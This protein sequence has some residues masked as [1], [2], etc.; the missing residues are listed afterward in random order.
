MTPLAG[1]D[2]AELTAWLTRVT[3]TIDRSLREG[4]RAEALAQLRD[5]L[6]GATAPVAILGQLALLDDCLRVAHLAIE[7]DGRVDPDELARVVE[8]VQV[9][10]PKYFSVLPRYESFGDGAPTPDEAERFLVVH[11]GDE[12]AFGYAS[13]ASWRGLALVRLVERHTRNAAPLRELERMLARIMDEVFAG[14]A[15]AIEQDARRRL[16]ALFEPPPEPGADPRDTAFCRADGPEVFSSVAH[17]SQIHD[18]DPFD[19]ESIHADARDVFHRQVVRAT[20][21]EQHHYG[22]G[23]TLL[24]LGDSGSGKTHLLRA[25]RHQVHAQRLGYVG[26][27]QMTSEVADYARYVLRNL[28][29]SL[30]RPYDAPAFA[31]SGLLYLSDGLAEGRGNLAPADVERLR[32]AEL[33]SD[34]LDRLLG[35]LVDQILRGD[36]LGQLEPDLV[37]ALLLLQRRDP[38]LQRRVIRFL[39]CEPLSA[40]ERRLLGGL[41]ARDQPDDPMRTLR[42]L[43]TIAYELQMATL[44]L[45]VDQIEDIVPDGKTVARLQQAIDVLRGI[46]D[47]VP[48][49]VVVMACLD[50]VYTALRGKLSQSVIDR[51]ERDPAPVRLASQR[52][53]EDIEAML[54]RRLDHLYSTFDVAIQDDDPCYPFTPD[55]LEAVTKLRARDAIAKFREFHEAC[56]AAGTI[57]GEAAGRSPGPTTTT[58]TTTTTATPTTAELDLAWND[59]LAAGG[60][61][62]D[63][64]GLLA[65]VGEAVRGAAGELGLALAVRADGDQLIVESQPLGR[66]VI[67]VCNG[68]PQGGHLGRQLDA[69]RA[70]VAPGV[71]PIALRSSDFQFTPKSKIARQAGEL[72]AAGGRTV[73][74]EESQLRAVV[75]ARGLAEA[76]PGAFAAWRQ[77]RRPLAHLAFVRAILDL[78]HVPRSPSV[79]TTQPLPH[80][81]RPPAP[82]QPIPVQPDPESTDPASAIP[83]S[84]A[85]ASAAPTAAASAAAAS[86]AA[87]PAA[88]RPS[89][90]QPIALDP[91]RIQLGETTTLRKEP[92]AIPIE[93][94]TT[95]VAVLGST[96]SGKTTAALS[97]VEQLL[98][99]ELSVLL[100]DRKGD[101]ARYASPA[102]WTDPAAADRERRAALRARI[103]VALF[104]PG[105]AAGR[106]LHL[107]VIPVLAD[108]SS[109]ERDQLAKFAAAGLAAMMGYGTGTTHR[110][111]LSVLQCA[112]QLH[113][114][115][116][117]VSI[118]LL[119]E[120]INRPDP[121]LLTRVGPLQ[122]FFAPLSED[123]QTL[124]IQR[125]ALLTGGGEPLDAASLLPP[126]GARPRLSIINTAA[127]T[128]VPVLQFWISRLLVELGRLART[129]PSKVLQGV[130]VLDEADAY[131]P[132]VG[133]PPTKEP[134]FELL[135][136]ARSGGLGILLATQ[137]PGDIDYKARDNIGTWL[138]G[139]VTQDRAIGKMENLL[140]GYPGVGPRLATQ[141]TGHF[142]MLGNGIRELKTAR[143]MMVTE[144]LADHDIAALARATR[145]G[146]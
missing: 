15:T 68:G 119:R 30:E 142:F 116:P 54:V 130:V 111:K 114:G 66:R 69:L 75:A 139:K 4:A 56:I 80:V 10:A 105:N 57:A 101:L 83:A 72:V 58:T 88:A 124:D 90:S 96:G 40:H 65:L 36:G 34:E 113:A 100:V 137:N 11:R 48:S 24:V 94:I 89:G 143:A 144:Q 85:P 126:P 117:E 107:P 63:D 127:L 70:L 71:V 51:L 108:A 67:E 123:L 98:E 22:Y 145:G 77:V 42:Q 50:D 128:E 27:L 64:D 109:Q 3:Q 95:H 135:R 41:V 17:G 146:E 120:T 91:A 86:T 26:Y 112:I 103:D 82:T 73:V 49:V 28:I 59:A 129:R 138:V 81:G 133:S 43:G 7:A 12:G 131:I 55:R 16:R 97:I 29:D 60:G 47:A 53:R 136:R 33:G 20:T 104:T 99:R 140:A 39:R 32:T 44:V 110:H 141:P 93:Q 35:A 102:W 106:P 31:E 21:P 38:A 132:A 92:V 46:A 13:R 6:G 118:E 9:A 74:V 45:L 121:E 8:L 122:R 76:L 5:G 84:A 125:G 61:L 23:R 19:V 18:R 115:E 2:R 78:D 37:H 1:L 134:M 87:A 62:P 25:L 52:Q 79:T 14:R